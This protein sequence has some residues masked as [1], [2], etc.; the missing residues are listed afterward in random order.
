[1]NKKQLETKIADLKAGIESPSTDEKYK[2]QLRELLKQAEDELAALSKAETPAEKKTVEKKAESTVEKAKKLVSKVKAE[3]KKAAGGVK[4]SA[5][6]LID[7]CRKLLSRNKQEKKTA[8]KRIESRKKAGKPV[9]LTP[10]ETVSKT[11]KAV[12]SKVISIKEKTDKG[13]PAGEVNKLSAGIIATIR[14]TIKGILGTGDKRV[15]LD[16]LVDE[17]NSLKSNLPKA[18]EFG[19]NVGFNSGAGMFARGGKISEKDVRSLY[20]KADA[21]YTGHIEMDGSLNYSSK[22]FGY[23]TDELAQVE[24]GFLNIDNDSSY[25]DELREEGLK[26]TAKQAYDILAHRIQ[27]IEEDLASGGSYAK[28]GKTA[29]EKGGMAEYFAKKKDETIEIEDENAEMLYS[30]VKEIKHHAE[31]ILSLMCAKTKVES[32][33]VAKGERSSTDLSDIYHYLDGRK[34]MFCC[35]G[36]LEEGGELEGTGMFAKGGKV[37]VSI[38]N[39]GEYNR[40]EKIDYIDLPERELTEDELSSFVIRDQDKN[41]HFYTSDPNDGSGIQYAFA[42]SKKYAKGGGVKDYEEKSRAMRATILA[43]QKS[44]INPFDV[45]P[46]FAKEMAQDIGHPITDKEATRISKGFGY[47]G[48]YAKGGGLSRDRMFVSQQDWEKNYKRK[49]AG[50][51]YKHE[52]G[53]AIV[54]YTDGTLAD[55][56]FDI[57]SP[58]FEKG[59]KTDM[60]KFYKINNATGVEDVVDK[61]LLGLNLEEYSKSMGDFQAS[62]TLAQLK[63]LIDLLK[64]HEKNRNVYILDSENNVVFSDGQQLTYYSSTKEDVYF[65]FEEGDKIRILQMQGNGKLDEEEAIILEKIAAEQPDGTFYPF[66]YV[67]L[68]GLSGKTLYS[69]DELIRRHGNK[70][71]FKRGGNLKRDRMFVSQQDWE[72]GYKR[73]TAGRRYKHERGG[74]VA[75]NVDLFEYYEKQP[76]KLK[77]IVDKYATMEQE[78]EM[79][80]SNTADFLKEVEAIGYTFDYGLDNQPFALRKKGVKINDLQG[81]EDFEDEESGMFAKGG[82][83]DGELKNALIVA[84][85]SVFSSDFLAKYDVV[86]DTFSTGKNSNAE[87][88]AKQRKADLQKEGY[89]VK[90]K[91]VNF[92]DL[93]RGTGYF[94]TAVKRKYAE[95]GSVLGEDT[96]GRVDDPSFS[97]SSTY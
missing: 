67:Q 50:R 49:T 92:D 64:K 62:L 8:A 45:S 58:V 83:I 5:K 63:D 60:P 74:S 59:G 18:A 44:K 68:M 55:P 89:A 84:G 72:K 34:Q 38:Y 78:G 33:V 97:D 85:G 7:D 82:G 19:G 9:E 36:S 47:E 77:V 88:L 20:E 80:Y 21:L 90:L 15:F 56:R 79:D 96:V 71:K 35:G 54:D 31:E 65:T 2:P 29:S 1:M 4:K 42:T 32:W 3:P 76:K 91:K 61:F 87:E 22:D 51:R 26:L 95:G 6:Q 73:K 66:Y 41:K 75:E 23:L 40:D 30:Q 10:S 70:P 93:A 69:Q 37:D 57:N 28:G 46:E 11:A 25:A 13:L 94:I 14:A 52:F 53:G 81:Y 24:V 86:K 16:D 27:S 48:S 43:I 12:T 39:Y 17:I